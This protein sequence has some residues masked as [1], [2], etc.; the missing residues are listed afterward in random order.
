MKARRHFLLIFL[1]VMIITDMF[2]FVEIDLS[3]MGR[4]K[5]T[6]Y[7]GILVLFIL[8]RHYFNGE[9]MIMKKGVVFMIFTPLF[10]LLTV[11][12]YYQQGILES[13]SALLGL[14]IFLLYYIF[15]IYAV[16]PD[17]ILNTF[18]F[19]G[20]VV[21][22]FQVIQ[23]FIPDEAV[24]GVYNEDQMYELESETNVHMRNGILHF[25]NRRIGRKKRLYPHPGR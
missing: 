12:L 6:I 23:Q 3:V 7:I 19:I 21:L 2:C 20:L 17:T 13:R 14:S 25:G 4:I 1:F 18:L 24:F 22:F 16:E 9:N 10:S 15:Y 5:N 11:V 8:A